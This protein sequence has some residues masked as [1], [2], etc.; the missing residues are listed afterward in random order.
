MDRV[1]E[2]SL[3]FPI[4]TV[5]SV[6]NQFRRS[7]ARHT[8]LIRQAVLAPPAVTFSVE[9]FICCAQQRWGSRIV[10]VCLRPSLCL[11]ACGLFFEGRLCT[12]S[13][14]ATVAQDLHAERICY[15]LVQPGEP[16]VTSNGKAV[17]L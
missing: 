6:N 5:G 12:I 3:I 16:P 17:V 8:P 2:T 14:N 1:F 7:D 15:F 10:L 9:F 11:P 4:C 13:R